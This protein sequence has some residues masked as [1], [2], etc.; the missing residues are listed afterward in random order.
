MLKPT[1]KTLAGFAATT[2]T[3]FAHPG[4]DDQTI[5][6]AMWVVSA[7]ALAG[8]CRLVVRKGRRR[9]QSCSDAKRVA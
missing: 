8:V 5:H 4:H 7:I 1:F 9:A 2:A 3:A 6:L